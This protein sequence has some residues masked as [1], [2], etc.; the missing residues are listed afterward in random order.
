MPRTS[1]GTGKHQ[2]REPLLPAFAIR[3]APARPDHNRCPGRGAGRAAKR[4]AGPGS[5]RGL[6]DFS[7]S[8]SAARAHGWGIPVPGDPD[9][10]MYVWFDALVNYVSALGYAGDESEFDQFWRNSATPRACHRQGH[11][12]ISCPLTGRPCCCRPASPLPTWVLVH[13]YITVRGPQDW[14]VGRQQHR[15]LCRRCALRLRCA[16]LLSAAPYTQHRGR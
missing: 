4:G 7:I 6:E 12:Q 5:I 8:R 16:A 13:G 11:H 9:Q 2:R 3:R 15:P 1:N 14:K 10:V